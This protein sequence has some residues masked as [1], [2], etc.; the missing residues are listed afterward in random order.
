MKGQGFGM[1]RGKIG[2][3]TAMKSCVHVVNASPNFVEGEGV[4]QCEVSPDNYWRGEKDVIVVRRGEGLIR[5][6]VMDVEVCGRGHFSG[7]DSAGNFGEENDSVGSRHNNNVDFDG[8]EKKYTVAEVQVCKMTDFGNNDTTYTCRTHLGRILN[9]GD[10]VL[11]YDMAAGD[12]DEWTEILGK[13]VVV[14]D[15][16]LVRKIRGT[17]GDEGEK[18][19]QEGSEVTE[20][21]QQ[22]QGEKQEGNKKKSSKKKLVNGRSGG[23]RGAKK[24]AGFEAELKKMGFLN[25]DDEEEEEEGEEEGEGEGEGEEEEEEEGEDEVV[26]D[27]YKEGADETMGSNKTK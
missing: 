1:L 17:A 24:Q 13:G 14:P 10:E 21:E 22:Q 23:Y 11:G 16:V 19:E 25:E 15:I 18:E 12:W 4:E 20:E 3:V 27:N 8:G 5:F 7:G 2:I 6:I 9:P 26:D